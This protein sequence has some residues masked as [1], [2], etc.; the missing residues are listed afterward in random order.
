[1]VMLFTFSMASWSNNSVLLRNYSRLIWDSRLKNTISLWHLD[2][3]WVFGILLYSG[4]SGQ[5]ILSILV[6]LVKLGCK[7]RLMGTCYWLLQLMMTDVGFIKP[8]LVF[9]HLYSDSNQ[10]QML[11][12]YM[13]NTTQKIKRKQE[14]LKLRINYPAYWMAKVLLSVPRRG[15]LL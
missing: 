1:M 13:Y 2:G 4:T 15:N 9:L 8:V 10:K 14:N 6:I 12:C 11:T 7:S 5:I 3:M